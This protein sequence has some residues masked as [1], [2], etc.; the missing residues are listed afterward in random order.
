[1]GTWHEKAILGE[2][3]EETVIGLGDWRTQGPKGIFPLTDPNLP[4]TV[5][6]RLTSADAH[7]RDNT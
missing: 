4:Q 7:Q 1:M 6:T 3:A 5:P 2:A